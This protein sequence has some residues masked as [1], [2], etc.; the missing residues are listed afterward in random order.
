MKKLEFNFHYPQPEEVKIEK[1]RPDKVIGVDKI[2]QAVREVTGN[3]SFQAG[4]IPTDLVEAVLVDDVFAKNN[5][6]Y[7]K[8]LCTQSIRI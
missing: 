4:P 6:K 5:S 3:K 7:T 1:V 8:L 2:V